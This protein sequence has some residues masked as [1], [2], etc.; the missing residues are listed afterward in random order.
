MPN[1]AP[2]PRYVAALLVV[3]TLILVVGSLLK[4]EPTAATEV[5]PA[6]PAQ[7]E[8]RRLYRLSLRSNVDR[9][10]EYFALVAGDIDPFLV[11]LADLE[12]SGIVWDSRTVV[13][14]A[15]GTMGSETTL[16][17][18]ASGENLTAL[19]LAAGP[20]LPLVG[21][22]LT[23][24]QDLTPAPHGGGG[25]DAGQWLLAAW[26]DEVKARHTPGNLIGST[27]TA[28]GEHSIEEV[29]TS[30]TLSRMMRGGGIF[31]IDGRLV[32]VI[33]EC[34]GRPIAVSTA[35]VSELLQAA[36]STNG[37]LWSGLGLKA[38]PL[39]KA[40]A[41]HLR[42]DSGILITETWHGYP[43]EG[44]GLRPGD[45]IQKLSGQ[46][47]QKSE[48][49]A[50]LFQTFSEPMPLVVRRGSRTLTLSLSLT[51]VEGA[52]SAPR[53]SRSGLTLES[54]PA[55]FPIESVR[56]G[57]REAVAGIRQGDRLLRV[58]FTEPRDLRELRRLLSNNRGGVVFVE[59]LRGD[60][61]VGLLL[62]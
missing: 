53:E 1:E 39:T 5:A 17:V 16:V 54:D 32:A 44:A 27:F 49:L 23:S 19:P 24:V 30:I 37:R 52:T 34:D 57:S 60:R 7:S 11:R 26:R 6:P 18:T 41:T 59:L 46:P 21:M 9:M 25:L 62:E 45:V 14:A 13:G 48:D 47:V 31:D 55:G 43:A 8:V 28:C 22:R 51:A 36:S 12:V 33:L 58:D 61:R 10:T 35:S 15:A 3:A 40:Q 50:P 38:N 20:D 4:P 42:T 2:S 56:P 29:E